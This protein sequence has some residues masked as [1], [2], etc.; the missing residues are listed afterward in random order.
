MLEQIDAHRQT[1]VRTTP[2]TRWEEFK[3][4]E[5]SIQV[6]FASER[7]I[8]M[9]RR[10][11][12]GSSLPWEAPELLGNGNLTVHHTIWLVACGTTETLGP[13]RLRSANE[14]GSERR[15]WSHEER[16]NNVVDERS[17]LTFIYHHLFVVCKPRQQEGGC[18]DTSKSKLT[19]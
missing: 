5:T 6:R 12:T 10:I 19:P 2:W 18:L 4:L 13:K 17:K 15:E 9:V 14:D 16:M 1:D 7:S 11:W 8:D 3:T